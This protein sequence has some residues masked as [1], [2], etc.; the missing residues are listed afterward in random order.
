VWPGLFEQPFVKGM[1]SWPENT[2]QTTDQWRTALLEWHDWA[3][4]I[5]L[6][7]ATENTFM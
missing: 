1:P 4:A 2:P 7:L 3:V 5:Y 6:I